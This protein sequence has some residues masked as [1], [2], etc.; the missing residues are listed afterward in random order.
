GRSLFVVH[1]DVSPHNVLVTTNGEVKMTDFG[2]AKALGKTSVTIAGQIKGKLAYMS[3]EQLMGGGID[4]RADVFALGCV[5]YEATTGE[6][7]FRGEND[8][9]VMAAIMIGNYDPP[10]S[11]RPDYPPDLEAIL[12]RALD[13]DPAKRFQTAQDM[14]KALED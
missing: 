5:L 8:P 6:K 13:S 2:V 7:P 10:R 14:R 12:V 9:Q 3:P 11:L 4:R 1:R